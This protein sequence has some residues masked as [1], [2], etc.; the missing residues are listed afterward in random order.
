MGTRCVGSEGPWRERALPSDRN[1]CAAGQGRE[2]ARWEGSGMAGQC[3]R[4]LGAAPQWG[5]GCEDLEREVG[6]VSSR[7]GP[8]NAERPHARQ[9]FCPEHLGRSWGGHSSWVLRHSFIS[10]SSHWPQGAAKNLK[11]GLSKARH[12]NMPVLRDC[13]KKKS[14]YN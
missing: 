1:K 2:L 3:A 10:H 8:Q 12:I 9:R 14:M 7:C 6:E 5:R 4:V 13:V 11:Y